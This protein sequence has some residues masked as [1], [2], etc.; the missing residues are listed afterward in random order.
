MELPGIDPEAVEVSVEDSTLTVRGEREFSHEDT[1]EGAFRRIERR[2][3]SF[4]RSLSL[5]KTADADRVE[6]SFDKG[7]LTIEVPK[8]EGAKPRKI[9]V[10]AAA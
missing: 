6:A 5:P 4:S 3:G 2:Y 8:R 9:T 10:K 1:D 7:V